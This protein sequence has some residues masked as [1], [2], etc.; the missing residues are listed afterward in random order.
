MSAGPKRTKGTG[1]IRKRGVKYWYV[2]PQ[3]NGRILQKYIGPFDFRHQAEAAG[4]AY[5][6]GLTNEPPSTNV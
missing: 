1:S 2:P 4:D 6:K 3:H 5:L